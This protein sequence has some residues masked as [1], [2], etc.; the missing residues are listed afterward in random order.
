MKRVIRFFYYLF[1]LDRRPGRDSAISVVK[2][3]SIGLGFCAFFWLMSALFIMHSQDGTFF[4]ACKTIVSGAHPI[5]NNVYAVVLGFFLV[6]IVIAGIVCAIA[7]AG[8]ALG[9]LAFFAVGC[10]M[11]GSWLVHDS[12]RDT[13]EQ[14][15][16]FRNV[17][18]QAWSRACGMTT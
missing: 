8:L 5:I 14:L 10:W 17:F 16:R 12:K 9:V 4:E 11:L 3:W 2:Q 15:Q 1:Q 18:K 13:L 6:C 7:F